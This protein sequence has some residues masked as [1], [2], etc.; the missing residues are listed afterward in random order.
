[1][2]KHSVCLYAELQS[3]FTAFPKRQQ[4]VGRGHIIKS[5]VY[6][7]RI[8]LAGVIRKKIFAFEVLWIKNAL[9]FGVVV[10][11]GAD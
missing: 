4:A 3:P 5:I 8:E 11:A 1:M 2:S 6:F 9:P 7:K 10:T